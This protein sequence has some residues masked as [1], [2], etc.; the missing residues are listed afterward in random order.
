VNLKFVRFQRSCRGSCANPATNAST[1]AV[2]VG[3]QVMPTTALPLRLGAMV[4]HLGPRFQ[5][6]NAE[7]ADPL[8]TRVR[9][10]V[11][12]DVLQE[13]VEVTDLE[14]WLTVEVQDRLRYPG[15]LAVY[16]GSELAAGKTDRLFLRAGY[17]ATDPDRASGASV[18]IGLR[19]RGF[20]FSVAKSLIVSSLTGGAEPLTAALSI[21]F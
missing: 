11:A 2:D 7:Q 12:Y 21:G 5:H 20:E 4:A 10:A 19:L 14:G 18:G 15:T 9:L 16:V 17:V 8:P 13:F 6:E 3:I 1:F